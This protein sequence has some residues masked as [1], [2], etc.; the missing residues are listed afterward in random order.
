M[1]NPLGVHAL[2]LTGGTSREQV[3]EAVDAA[4]A[5]PVTDAGLAA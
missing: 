4:A 2:V 3:R 1:R 5:A